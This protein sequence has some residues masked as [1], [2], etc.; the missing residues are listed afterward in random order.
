MWDTHP[1]AYLSGRESWWAFLTKKYKIFHKVYAGTHKHLMHKKVHL[2]S[3]RIICRKRGLQ[4]GGIMWKGVRMTWMVWLKSS[5]M[6][7]YCFHCHKY[8]NGWNMRQRLCDHLCAANNLFVQ[9]K[10]HFQLCGHPNLIMAQEL[11]T[12]RNEI[13]DSGCTRKLYF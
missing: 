9:S 7:N 11:N 12:S 2:M 5:I 8:E 6:M 3:P 10:P 1:L 4:K 13:L